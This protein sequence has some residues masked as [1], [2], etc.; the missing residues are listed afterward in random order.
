MKQHTVHDPA[1]AAYAGSVEQVWSNWEPMLRR[2][3]RMLHAGAIAF[4][5]DPEE[6]AATLRQAQYRAHTTSEFA[7]ALQ[8]PTIV[9][10]AHEYLVATLDATRETLGALAVRVE[11]DEL[12]EHSAEIGLQTVLATREA[13]ESARWSSSEAWQY[14][15]GLEPLYAPDPHGTPSGRGGTLLWGLVGVCTV[16]FAVLLVQVLVLS[17]PA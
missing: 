14:S 17:Q 11:L 8:P 9:A 6:G 12:D 7:S 2:I 3:E 4:E 13:F 5:H 1:I 10:D 16:L 15:N